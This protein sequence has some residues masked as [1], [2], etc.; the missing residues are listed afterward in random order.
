MVILD[1]IAPAVNFHL[2]STDMV[3]SFPHAENRRLACYSPPGK[4]MP[5]RTDGK[6]DTVTE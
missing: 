4:N 3:K 1:E 2:L 6:A 5:K